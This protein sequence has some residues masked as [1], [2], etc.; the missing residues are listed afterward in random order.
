MKLLTVF[1]SLWLAMT[2]NVF[3]TPQIHITQSSYNVHGTTAQA[4]RAEMNTQ[5]PLD[6]GN[7]VDAMTTWYIKWHYNYSSRGYCALTN[8]VVTGDI[9]YHLPQWVDAAKS[10]AV[11][12]NKWNN[13]L[14]KLRFHEE[15]HADNGKNAASEIERALQTLPAAPNCNLLDANAT[16]AARAILKQH[17]DW[18]LKYDTDTRH[19]ATQG[20]VFP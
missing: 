7:H 9:N 1:I 16:A 18:D 10:D 4:M 8:I 14:V 20:A 15:G 17:N 19:G 12:Q 13:Y 3:A 6:H 11:L 2:S 5:G